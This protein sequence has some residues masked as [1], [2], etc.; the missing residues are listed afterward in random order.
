MRGSLPA[1]GAFFYLVFGHALGEV[2]SRNCSNLSGLQLVRE[3][4]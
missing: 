2:H 1:N 3:S 4:S